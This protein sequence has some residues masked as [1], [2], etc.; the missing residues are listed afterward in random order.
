MRALFTALLL[1]GA[2]PAAASPVVLLLD[3]DTP[4]SGSELATG[5]WLSPLG[6]IEFEG[7]F[8]NIDGSDPDFDAAGAVGNGLDIGDGSIAELRFAFDV[9]SV[10]FVYGGNAGV[11]DIAA[12]DAMGDLV[13]SFFQAST[14]DGQPAGP[15]TL[16]GPGIR[17]L[18]WQ[19]PGNSFAPID[20]LSVATG[21]GVVPAPAALALFGLA[22]AGLGAA[23][24]R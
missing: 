3:F 22:F 24:C 7:E 19:D 17:R 6:L 1:A 18:V 16:S 15:E 11:F 10:S 21:G 12:Y 8:R 14:D 13:D 2:A 20:N 23:R 9:D 5:S 4:D